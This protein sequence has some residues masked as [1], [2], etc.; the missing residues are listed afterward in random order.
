MAVQVEVGQL[1]LFCPCNLLGDVVGDFAEVNG[2]LTGIG[3]GQDGVVGPLVG[4]EL[5]VGTVGLAS[6]PRVN[7]QLSLV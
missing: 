3:D 5:G 6:R 7:D 2:Q 1:L 4:H